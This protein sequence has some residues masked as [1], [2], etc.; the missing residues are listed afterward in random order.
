MLIADSSGPHDSDM[1]FVVTTTTTIY[2]AVMIM[3]KMIAVRAIKA[4]GSMLLLLAVLGWRNHKSCRFLDRCGSHDNDKNGGYDSSY[5]ST[6]CWVLLVLLSRS[7]RRSKKA[8]TNMT[9][10]HSYD[11]DD[12]NL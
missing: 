12:T 11:Y 2:G 3:K 5:L 10:G 7:S 6:Y 9:T 4:V 8:S 1:I